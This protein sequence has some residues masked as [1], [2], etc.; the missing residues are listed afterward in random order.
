MATWGAHPP[1]EIIKLKCPPDENVKNPEDG[2]LIRN[3]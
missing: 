1:S 3:F 2:K